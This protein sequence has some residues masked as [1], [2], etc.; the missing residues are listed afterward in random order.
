M[1]YPARHGR[2]PVS[3]VAP[4]ASE[5]LERLGKRGVRGRRHIRREHH[6]GHPLCDRDQQPLQRR[7]QF[8]HPVDQQPETTQPVGVGRQQRVVRAVELTPARLE[9]GKELRQRSRL[10]GRIGRTLEARTQVREVVPRSLQLPHQPVERLAEPGHLPD[11]LEVPVLHACDL[12]QQH[13][14]R[15]R[16]QRPPLLV[17][18]RR[19]AKQ[20]R[21]VTGHQDPDVRV[22]PE[23][24]R[25]PALQEWPLQRR[26]DE[27]RDRR[28][29]IGGAQLPHPVC[30][31]VPQRLPAR[32]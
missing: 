3:S 26:S 18:Q 16:R 8:E 29:G 7:R 2:V 1:P 21:Q 12:R 24:R 19:R 20:Q 11:R 32:Q 15:Q 6:D 23:P 27:H 14:V 4:A 9:R 10:L 31:L 25:E 13:P 30:E 17:H 5:P 22:C 28:Q